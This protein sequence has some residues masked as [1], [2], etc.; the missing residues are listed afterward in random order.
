MTAAVVLCG[1][2][3]IRLRPLTVDTPKPLIPIA[4]RPIVDY[5][6]DFLKGH[7][8]H[9]IRVAGGYLVEEIRNHFRTSHIKVFDTGDV[10]IISRIQ[11]LTESHDERILVLYG[12]TLSDVNIPDLLAFSSQHFDKVTVTVWPLRSNF[13]VFSID[14]KSQVTKYFEK[15]TL[16]YWINIGYFVIPPAF[17]QLLKEFSTFEELL[18]HLT[19][20][21]LLVAYRH[22]GAHITINTRAELEDAEFQLDQLRL[23]LMGDHA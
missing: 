19:S 13:G 15:P 7:E 22:T 20:Q 10:D 23:P 1:G 17:F 8:V 11:Q 9:D 21:K 2:R 16:D 4:G 6:I 3:G 12:D 14:E 5:I 18:S